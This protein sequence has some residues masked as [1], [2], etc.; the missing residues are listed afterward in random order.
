MVLGAEA[1]LSTK[2]QAAEWALLAVEALMREDADHFLQLVSNASEK[3]SYVIHEVL[4]AAENVLVAVETKS[5]PV[6]A[7]DVVRM[8]TLI[9]HFVSDGLSE[10]EENIYETPRGTVLHVMAP[11][12]K[13]VSRGFASGPS[14]SLRW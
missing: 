4:V 2:R 8:F 5:L 14:P 11:S 3:S 6:D 9:G 12:T 7:E 1:H 10:N 13:R